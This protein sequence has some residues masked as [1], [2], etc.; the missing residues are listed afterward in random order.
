MVI[1]VVVMVVVVVVVGRGGWWAFAGLRRASHAHAS[2]C[3]MYVKSTPL[4]DFTATDAVVVVM[5]VVMMALASLVVIT[6]PASRRRPH[7]GERMVVGGHGLGVGV[8]ARED[9]I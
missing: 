2:T 8:E 1:V 9:T 6:T 7:R 3:V 5:V 4:A